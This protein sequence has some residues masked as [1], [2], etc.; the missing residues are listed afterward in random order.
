MNGALRY[1]II[2]TARQHVHVCGLAAHAAPPPRRRRPRPA[3]SRGPPLLDRVEQQP[4]LI[5]PVVGCRE[6]SRLLHALDHFGIRLL[7]RVADEE[8]GRRARLAPLWGDAEETH[9]ANVPADRI[10]VVRDPVFL[11]TNPVSGGRFLG[12]RLAMGPVSC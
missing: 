1:T 3:R 5:A 7:L 12:T 11:N 2:R 6:L 9:A 4:P 8:V 10:G